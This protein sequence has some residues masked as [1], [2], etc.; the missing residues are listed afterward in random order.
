MYTVP[1]NLD[2]HAIHGVCFD[3]PWT[4]E[5]ASVDRVRLSIAFDDRWPFGGRAVQEVTLH[6]TCI[7]LRLEVH[8]D[9]RAFPAGAG[10]HPWFRRDV[11]GTTDPRVRVEADEL[12]EL[13]T[14]IPTGALLAVSG[15]TDLKRFPALGTRRLD[16]CYR[17]PRPPL[18]VR[19]TDLEL[20]IGF[21]ANV[22]HAVV[23]TPERGFCLEP[24]T[25]AIDAFNLD[26]R[27]SLDSGVQVVEPGRPLIVETS[28][29]W[30][31]D[32]P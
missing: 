2:G 1:S 31:F 20:D 18:R 32:A 14:M 10:W 24:Q 8:A 4:V 3:C 15:E 25:C 29:R 30:R 17:R 13:E 26:A 12:Y 19:W 6:E 21:S 16:T 11:R 22:T 23:Y 28:W 5:T 27:T 9:D 7:D